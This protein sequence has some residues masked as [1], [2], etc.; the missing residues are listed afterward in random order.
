MIKLLFN[1]LGFV[2]LKFIDS[3]KIPK[4]YETPPNLDSV[5]GSSKDSDSETYDYMS[6]T[7]LR[8]PKP[9]E[10]MDNLRRDTLPR[11]CFASRRQRKNL[12]D[13]LIENEDQE[14]ELTDEDLFE[15][16]TYVNAR[17]FMNYFKNG[18]FPNSLGKALGFD[19]D[20][21]RN[22][23]INIPGKVFCNLYDEEQNP[24]PCE[25]IPSV[26]VDWPGEQA[27]EFIMREERPTITDRQTGF[28]YRWPTDDMI[29][30][31][32]SLSCVLIPTGYWPKKGKDI[33]AEIEWQIAFPKAERYIESCMSHSQ[34]R[35][36]LFLLAL[37]KTFIEP[38]TKQH[39]LLTEHIRCHMYWE[40]ERDYR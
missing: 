11:T 22:Q 26:A 10:I 1:F 30:E 34:M 38:E 37:H 7:E 4:I 33:N 25:V 24:I 28:R 19:E 16:V 31:I 13:W 2:R 36:F 35:C 21:I 3:N 27:F 20:E 9:L 23:A 15:T 39:G 12:T 32:Q 5:P 29:K 14:V 8:T 6:I 18:L 17:G 40:C